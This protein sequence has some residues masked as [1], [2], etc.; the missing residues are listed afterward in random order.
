MLTR[1]GTRLPLKEDIISGY[2]AAETSWELID[3]ESLSP[4]VSI[5]GILGLRSPD[6]GIPFEIFD[7]CSYLLLPSRPEKILPRTVSPAIDFLLVMHSARYT[8][9]WLR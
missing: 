9:L 1:A 2:C 3:F 6:A 7:P 5:V 8:F 4:S